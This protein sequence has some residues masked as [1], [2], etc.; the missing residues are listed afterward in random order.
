M[1]RGGR[2]FLRSFG[3]AGVPAWGAGCEHALWADSIDCL[4]K[5]LDAWLTL[6]NGGSV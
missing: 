5:I 1:D 2:G 4:V 3:G 6:L